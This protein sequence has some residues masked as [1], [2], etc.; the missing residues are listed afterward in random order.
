M[1]VVT[2][3]HTANLVGHS[4]ESMAKDGD[5]R[6][7][8]LSGEQRFSESESPTN[9]IADGSQVLE[10]S[11]GHLLEGPMIGFSS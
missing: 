7:L 8:K 4:H 2:P 9:I 6:G 3:S 1:I 11:F 10:A 5:G